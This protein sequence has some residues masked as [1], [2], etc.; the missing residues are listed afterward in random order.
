MRSLVSGGLDVTRKVFGENMAI[1][2]KTDINT[3]VL[4]VGSGAAGTMA[5]IQAMSGADVLVV[6]KGPFPSGDS[7]KAGGAL[8][9]ALGNADP[10][11]TPQV[12]FMD[13][14][15]NGQG[16]S[17]QKVVRAWVNTIVEVIREMDRWG[18]DLVRKDGK[19]EQKLRSG[20]TYPCTVH[21]HLATGKAVMACLGKKSRE[22]G[23]KVLDHT[24]IG[25]L[26]RDRKKVVGA[27][28]LQCQTGQLLIIK[29]KSVVLA[30][31]GMGHLFPFTDNVRMITGEGY[32]SAF[33]AGAELIQME[34]CHFS[35]TYCYPAN[36]DSR[37]SAPLGKLIGSGARLY[38]NLGERFMKRYYPNIG[39]QQNDT[40]L[41]TRAIGLEIC[42]G[43]GGPH[44]GVYLDVSEV[45]AETL[46]TDFAPLWDSA[47]RDGINLSHQ[48][49]ELAP[50]PHDF[51]GGIKIDE[52]GSAGMPGLFA[53]GEADGG[54]HGASRLPGS[55]LSEALA[56][57]A[58][59]GRSAALYAKK[60]KQGALD[61]EQLRATE[62]NLKTVLSR[63][64]GIKS[65]DLKKRIHKI[66]FRYLNAGRNEAGLTT[67]LKELERIEKQ[68]LPQISAWAD[69]PK[70]MI[71][72]L[73]EAIEA[74]G[75]LELAKAIA[76]AALHRK[77]S[78]SGYFGG[79]YRSDYPSQ[80]DQNWL[81][82]IVLKR[83]PDGTITIRSESP[84]T[85]DGPKQPDDAKPG[86]G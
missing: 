18:I 65:S 75:Q 11:D 50:S 60:I 6:T 38:N 85:E 74:D 56:L 57:G 23:I 61:G 67:A 3:D 39:D 17:N 68:E 25:G 80:D 19:F 33:R 69:D 44:G 22:M 20:Y 78:R 35:R 7:S 5:A 8:A 71:A 48:P 37:S 32:T 66:A 26:L 27:W 53:A 15:K 46:K 76:T 51:L 4:V 9:V 84:V 79:F 42:E 13:V 12:H 41:I 47:A 72:L 81:K 45:A 29:A 64:K 82:N 59:S 34:F 36:A 86:H 24:I 43:R 73:Q 40:E 63:Q 70:Q 16:L 58:I 52:T 21:H 30:T 49:V 14:V 10:R 2:E 55:A 31:G 1:L 77:E 83:K 54:A 28:G 62:G